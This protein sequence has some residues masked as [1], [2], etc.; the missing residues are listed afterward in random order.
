MHMVHDRCIQLG[1]WHSQACTVSGSRLLAGL[2]DWNNPFESCKIAVRLMCH[3]PA[4]LNS[5]HVNNRHTKQRAFAHQ[6]CAVRSITCP[7]AERS[8]SCAPSSN[9][10]PCKHLSARHRTYVC[11]HVQLVAPLPRATP[12][13][14][15]TRRLPGSLSSSSPDV[16]SIHEL[17]ILVPDSRYLRPHWVRHAVNSPSTLCP[18]SIWGSL[19]WMIKQ[20][21][22]PLCSLT[23]R[24]SQHPP[25]QVTPPG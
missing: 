12:S 2:S 8:A 23:H 21:P 22:T 19:S 15:R 1:L 17:I 25:P 11:M 3:T 24:R 18:S 10:F 5:R 16:H 7:A 20:H 13:S 9:P 4:S 6:C 14:P